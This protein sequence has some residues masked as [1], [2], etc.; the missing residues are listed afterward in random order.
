MIGDLDRNR[1]DNVIAYGSARGV[2][3]VRPETWRLLDIESVSY[4]RSL[5]IIVVS[6]C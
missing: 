5:R 6:C 2:H 4:Q 3:P 1:V